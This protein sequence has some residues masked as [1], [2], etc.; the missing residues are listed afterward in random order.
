[1]LSHRFLEEFQCRLLVTRF[2]HEAFRNLTLG[3]DGAPKVALLVVDLSED[4]IGMPLQAGL[5]QPFD[6]TFLDLMNQQW[7]APTESAPPCGLRKSLAIARDLRSCEEI[8]G[9]ERTMPWLGK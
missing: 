8:A 5:S 6:P 1:M 3:N 4:Q 9:T 2:C 7:S